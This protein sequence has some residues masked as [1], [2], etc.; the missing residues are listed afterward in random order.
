[1]LKKWERAYIA[2]LVD[3]DGCIWI[4]R[5]SNRPG[6]VMYV[7]VTNTN[8]ELLN[9]LKKEWGGCIVQF[10]QT[11]NSSRWAACYAWKICSIQALNFLSLTYQFM[12]VKLE[13]AVMA[14]D[15]QELKADCRGKGLC[16]NSGEALWR[17]SYKNAISDLNQ[18][19]ENP[20]LPI[21]DG[22]RM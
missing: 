17:E 10:K 1:M 6:H 15:F 5:R 19:K 12:R 7:N 21:D 9:W 2:G 11:K 13:R 20:R 16:I 3:A 14:I 18:R 4:E 22:R 8:L